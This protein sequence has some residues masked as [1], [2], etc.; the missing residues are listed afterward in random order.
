MKTTVY[1]SDLRDK[2]LIFEYRDDG[3][4]LGEALCRKPFEKT[5]NPSIKPNPVELLSDWLES[6]NMTVDRVLLIEVYQRGLTIKVAK[7][8]YEQNQA[9]YTEYSIKLK[10]PLQVTG[11]AIFNAFILDCQRRLF[12]EKISDSE[13]EK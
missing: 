2:L 4:F 8:I 6:K 1:I 3:V 7:S 10:Q 5:V 12:K 11:R 13:V 9:R